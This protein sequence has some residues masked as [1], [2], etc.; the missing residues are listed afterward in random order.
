[1]VCNAQVPRGASKTDQAGLSRLPTSGSGAFCG[2]VS[3]AISHFTPI[4]TPDVGSTVLAHCI[5]TL[6]PISLRQTWV[7]GQ[8]FF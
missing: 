5:Q 4:P 6:G 1:M 8:F 3:A 7:C 2:T